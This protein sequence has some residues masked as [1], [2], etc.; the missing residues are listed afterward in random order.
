MKEKSRRELKLLEF[1]ATF[2]KDNQSITVHCQDCRAIL[3]RDE[4]LR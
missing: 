1:D 3:C 4:K 2:D